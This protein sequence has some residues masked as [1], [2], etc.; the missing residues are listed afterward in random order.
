MPQS[1]T[2][3]VGVQKIWLSMLGG[4]VMS[5]PTEW[6][7]QRSLNQLVFFTHSKV[8]WNVAEKNF[9]VNGTFSSNGT[10]CNKKSI[11]WAFCG[12]TNLPNCSKWVL[13]TVTKSVEMKY[14][15]VVG[16][17]SLVDEKPASNQL[18][19]ANQWNCWNPLAS[20]TLMC[21]AEMTAI[22]RI[23]SHSDAWTLL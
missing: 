1:G 15:C 2:W 12:R 19:N 21:I 14:Q 13:R 22:S 3:S 10:A 17:V 11:F 5:G 9:L 7:A 20:L 4:G 18:E 6:T 16:I 8:R 23:F